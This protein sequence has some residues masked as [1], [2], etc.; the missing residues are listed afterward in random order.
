M[1]TLVEPPAAGFSRLHYKEKTLFSAAEN[2]HSAFWPEADAESDS[3]MVRVL[4]D[5]RDV[6]ACNATYA[7]LNFSAVRLPD[8][9]RT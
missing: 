1:C 5:G 7:A 4:R 2:G 6:F 3:K 8:D 9:D